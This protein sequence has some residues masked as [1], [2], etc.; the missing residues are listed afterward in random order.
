MKGLLRVDN[1]IIGK[2]DLFAID[3]LDRA[4]L[5]V[6]ELGAAGSEVLRDPHR[7]TK[8]P[9]TPADHPES[10]GDVYDD[11]LEAHLGTQ[12]KQATP[13]RRKIQPGTKL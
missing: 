4:K 12:R 10:E 11:A 6:S 5:V 8:R 1:P 7:I 9:D 3:R 13:P 2:G